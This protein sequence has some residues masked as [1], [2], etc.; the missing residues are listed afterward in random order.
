MNK[1]TIGG[2]LFILFWI[3]LIWVL[4]IRNPTKPD[5]QTDGGYEPCKTFGHPL[6]SDC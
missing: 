3:V 6:Y 1:K 4:A 2:I 5:L